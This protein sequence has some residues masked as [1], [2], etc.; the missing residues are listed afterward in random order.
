MLFYRLK[1][2]DTNEGYVARHEL[3][4]SLQNL[5]STS[6][7]LATLIPPEIIDYVEEGRNPDIYTREFVEQVQK[8]NMILKGK[9][10]AY[11][12]FRDM[13]AEEIVKEGMGSQEE[14]DERLQSYVGEEDNDDE[15]KKEA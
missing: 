1:L 2:C 3:T 4:T 14:V 15:V 7:N 13:L 8:L 11:R 6:A 9:S 5:S 12:G 10:D